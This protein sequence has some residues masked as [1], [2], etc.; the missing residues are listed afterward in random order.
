MKIIETYKTNMIAY[1]LSDSTQKTYLSEFKAYYNYCHQ[2][3]LDIRYVSKQN[4]IKYLAQLYEQGYSPSK[5]N[6]AINAIKFYKEKIKG[7]KRQTY[8][9][10]RPKQRKF[11]PL[12]LSPEKVRDICLNTQNIKHRAI[13]FL[14]YDSGIRRSELLKLTIM[15]VRTKTASPHLIIR[16]SKGR[17][18]RIALISHECVDLVKQYYRDYKPKKWLFEGDSANGQYSA[19]SLKNILDAACKREGVNKPMRIHDLRHNFT[20]HCIAAG[21][22]M[23]FISDQLGHDSVRTTEKYYTHLIAEQRKIIRPKPLKTQP[24]KVV[25]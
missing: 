20:T 2:H 5:I 10:P 7:E 1:H 13:L 6:Q 3:L 23:K 16:A 12:I 19:T 11:M 8:Y 25:V 17:K 24:L 15:D 9:L 14:F 21:T 18:S 22:S 4:I